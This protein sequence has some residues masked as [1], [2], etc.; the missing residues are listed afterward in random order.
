[1]SSAIRSRRSGPSEKWAR[2]GT[3]RAARMAE[4][5]SIGPSPPRGTYAGRPRDRKRTKA[6]STLVAYPRATIARASVGRPRAS[7]SPAGGTSAS[8]KSIGMPGSRRR[9]T[10]RPNRT[11]RSPR[12]RC[13]IA[14]KASS[15]GSTPEPE[16]VDLALHELG[17][18]AP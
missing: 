17:S 6:S 2:D 3:P 11:R 12:W 14:S 15:S 9:S 18:I 4:I 16:D 1:M 10:I 8:A 7:S 5:A 13:R